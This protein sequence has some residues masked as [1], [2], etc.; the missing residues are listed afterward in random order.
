MKEQLARFMEQ[1]GLTQ[2]QVAKALVNVFRC[3]L[4]SAF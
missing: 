3:A 1:K 2:T 4:I